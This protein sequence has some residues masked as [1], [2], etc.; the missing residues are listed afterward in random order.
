ME[1]YFRNAEPAPV[2][3]GSIF[4]PTGADNQISGGYANKKMSPKKA[5]KLAGAV[6]LTAIAWAITKKLMK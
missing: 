3:N 1:A 4:E 6:A 2:T 5:S